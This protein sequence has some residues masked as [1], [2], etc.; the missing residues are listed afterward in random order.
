MVRPTTQLCSTATS[1]DTGN[2]PIAW[3]TVP[4]RETVLCLIAR[5]SSRVFLGEELCRNEDW[6]KITRDYTVD[7]FKAAEFLRLW[8]T[9]IRFIVHWFLP[10]CRV[11]RAHVATA[12]RVIDPVIQKRREQKRL[13]SKVEFDDAL[14]WFEKESKG[15]PYDPAIGQLVLS[16]AAIHTT[17]DLV[18]QVLTDLTQH[19]EMLEPL[20]KEIITALQDGG[21]KKT[22]LYNMKL[23]DSV[24][25]ESQRMKPIG[26]GKP[27]TLT[28]LPHH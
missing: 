3:Q 23:L 17:T 10:S 13:D 25:K 12:R 2:N 5:I 21:W 18:C 6:L 19:P 8:P 28:H 15:N 9:S 14:E 20:R 26:I 22:S 27:L 24:I 16:M 1:T 7:S 11:A 4:L